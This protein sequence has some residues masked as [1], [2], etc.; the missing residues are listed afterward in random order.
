M[1]LC[2]YLS[3]GGG[4]I[5]ICFQLTL[6]GDEVSL[7]LVSHSLRHQRLAAARGAIEQH[8]PGGR[9]AEFFE[10]LGVFDRVLDQLLQLALD[11]LSQ[12]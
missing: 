7:A 9:H 8:T 11:S 1:Y 4:G 10:L 2:I 6:D 5:S 12:F 3:L